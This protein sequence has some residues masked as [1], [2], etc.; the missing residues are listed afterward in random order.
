MAGLPTLQVVKLDAVDAAKK[1]YKQSYFR[2]CGGMLHGTTKEAGK[3][4]QVPVVN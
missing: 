3:R 4:Y 1:F 2:R